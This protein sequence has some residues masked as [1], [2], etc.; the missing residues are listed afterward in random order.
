[1]FI[2][3]N[4]SFLNLKSQQQQQQQQQQKQQHQQPAARAKVTLPIFCF[5]SVTDPGIRISWTLD[6]SQRVYPDYSLP[7]LLH[8]T[9]KG[10]VHHFHHE[11][12][13]GYKIR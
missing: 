1:M 11:G 4:I 8:S 6:Y 5:A 10:S 7:T 9:F 13:Q 2:V 3:Y 12:V